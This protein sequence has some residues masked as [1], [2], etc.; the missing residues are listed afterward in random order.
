MVDALVSPAG[1]GTKAAA[2]YHRKVGAGG[3]ISLDLRLQPAPDGKASKK[4]FQDFE[5]VLLFSLRQYHLYYGDIFKVECPTSS[6]KFMNLNEVAEELGRRLS[7]IF[8]RD[9]GGKRA[10]FGYCPLFNRDPN[11]HGLIPFHEYF[12]GDT[13]RGCGASHQTG[14]TGLIAQVVMNLGETP[15]SHL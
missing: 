3:T 8:L 14:W 9:S 7:R 13:G 2:R 15:I 6:G 12:H 1:T 5:A 4:P 11:W 10:V